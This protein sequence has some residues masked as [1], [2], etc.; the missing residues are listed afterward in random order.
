[1]LSS[2]VDSM[3]LP[4]RLGLLARPAGLAVVCATSM[5]GTGVDIDRLGLM[6]VHGQPKTT[7]TYIQATGR[8]GR[9]GGALVVSFLRASRPRD[10]DHYEY[11]VGYHR[12]LYRHVEAITVSPFAPKAR[13]R[14]LGPIAVSLLRQASEIDG[15]QVHQDW[16]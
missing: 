7:A 16:R 11:F 13:E 6:V 10:L 9:R 5:F 12:S 15:Q 4:S 2:R 1:E 14:A 3:E 8:V